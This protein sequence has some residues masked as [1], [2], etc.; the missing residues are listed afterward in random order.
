MSII[1][2]V[3]IL[4]YVF[5]QHYFVPMLKMFKPNIRCGTHQKH[6][7]RWVFIEFFNVT[8]IVFFFYYYLL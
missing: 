4:Y 7:K 6:L 8:I 3:L 2:F 5:S 1:A